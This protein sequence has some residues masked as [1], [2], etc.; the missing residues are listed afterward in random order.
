[1]HAYM[2]NTLFENFTYDAITGYYTQTIIYDVDLDLS[3]SESLDVSNQE[4]LFISSDESDSFYTRD[5]NLSFDRDI[6]FSYSE[7]GYYN[8]VFNPDTGFFSQSS[9][10]S[11]SLEIS[12]EES[13]EISSEETFVYLPKEPVKTPI[14]P[15]ISIQDVFMIGLLVIIG[16]VVMNIGLIIY[17]CCCVNKK[18]K[19]SKKSKI[20][21][22]KVALSSDSEL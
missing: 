13:V 8:L 22:S 4:T 11:S 16:L 3:L 1:M 2:R 7:R 10:S 20:K 19:C 21:Y 17:I 15:G 18:N 6:D 14:I 12:F 9:F 5:E